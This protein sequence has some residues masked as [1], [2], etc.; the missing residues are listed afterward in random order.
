MKIV[1]LNVGCLLTKKEGSFYDRNVGLRKTKV[2][3]LWGTLQG[4][5]KD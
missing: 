2:G 5:T 1:T 4:M 3:L